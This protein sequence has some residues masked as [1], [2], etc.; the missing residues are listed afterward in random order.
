M[1]RSL[2]TPLLFPILIF[3]KAPLLKS[4][5]SSP[6]N[7]IL[8]YDCVELTNKKCPYKSN[9][10]AT[11]GMYPLNEIAIYLNNSRPYD[12]LL[13]TVRHRKL[14]WYG[15]VTRSSGLTKTI[16]QGTVPGGRKIGRQKK[17]WEDNIKEWTGLQ[18]SD[19]LRK[20][21]SREEWRELVAKTPVVP[22]QSMTMG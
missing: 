10:L 7:R 2:C 11:S 17:R 6:I 4:S 21:E 9:I 18:L 8:I 12:D 5:W 3:I 14:K 1:R 13:T 22:W 15:H 20:A 16:L 19:T